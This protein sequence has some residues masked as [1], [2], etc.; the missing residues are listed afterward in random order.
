MAFFRFND[1]LGVFF[2]ARKGSDFLPLFAV[3]WYP[4]M[5]RMLNFIVDGLFSF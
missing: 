2:K 3:S 1:L 4:G 5:Q